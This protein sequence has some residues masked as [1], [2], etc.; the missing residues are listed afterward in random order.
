MQDSDIK[1]VVRHY[2]K[3]AFVIKRGWRSLG[4]RRK[5]SIYQKVAACSAALI[6]LSAA[7]VIYF[8]FSSPEQTVPKINQPAP[9]KGNIRQSLPAQP[10]EAVVS[11]VFFDN[12]PLTVVI[13]EIETVYGVQVSN[14]PDNADSYMLTLHY[15]GDAADLVA[16]INELL[17]IN[18]ILIE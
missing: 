17:E 14:L 13:E 1:F 7:A 4:I 18:L 5:I 6:T 9:I 16:T 10:A 11:S 2:R 8:H 12:A 15:E 3:G